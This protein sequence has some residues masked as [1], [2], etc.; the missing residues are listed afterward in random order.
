VREKEKNDWQIEEK[1]R[2]NKQEKQKGQA[3]RTGRWD[4]DSCQ[5]GESGKGRTDETCKSMQAEADR[6]EDSL[7][8]HAGQAD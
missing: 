3:S 5:T 7:M 4:R 2:K 1:N 6:K 8:K